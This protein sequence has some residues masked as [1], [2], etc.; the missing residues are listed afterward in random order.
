M[1]ICVRER[2]HGTYSKLLNV[3]LGVPCHTDYD[4]G[5]I[6]RRDHSGI[7]PVGYACSYSF[8]PLGLGYPEGV[9]RHNCGPLV[10]FIFVVHCINMDIADNKTR[11]IGGCAVG[12]LV[13]GS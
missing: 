8:M 5:V 4:S 2:A 7:I 9:F 6:K 13:S 3:S 1:R 12:P 11:G 10:S